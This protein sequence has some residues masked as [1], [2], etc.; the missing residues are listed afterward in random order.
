ML[1]RLSSLGDSNPARPLPKKPDYIVGANLGLTDVVQTVE[2]NMLHRHERRNRLKDE[3]A[4]RLKKVCLCVFMYMYV[5]ESLGL[6]VC[7]S[8]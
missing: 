7:G 3:F 6:T 4:E 1:K 5:R 8:L 2:D